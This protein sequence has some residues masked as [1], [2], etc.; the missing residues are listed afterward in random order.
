[1]SDE[2]KIQTAIREAMSPQAVALAIAHLQAAT[3]SKNK[4]AVKEVAWLVEVLTNTAGGPDAVNALYE[5]IGV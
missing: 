5:E 1:M 4:Q 3:C 2:E